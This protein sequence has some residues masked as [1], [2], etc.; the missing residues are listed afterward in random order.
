MSERGIEISHSKRVGPEREQN[1]P[2]P[3]VVV[4]ASLL[5]AE[6]IYSQRK[7]FGSIRVYVEKNLSFEERKEQQ[8]ERENSSQALAS[9]A[10]SVPGPCEQCVPKG[11]AA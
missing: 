7:E 4:F 10:Q 8:K 6:D 5:Q 1:K 3:L 9:V 2:K 11:P